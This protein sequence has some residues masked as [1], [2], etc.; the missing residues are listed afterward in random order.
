MMSCKVR[1]LIFF[2]YF[3]SKYSGVMRSPAHQAVL[4]VQNYLEDAVRKLNPVNEV[5]V[6]VSSRTDS[7]VHA[8]CNTAHVDIQRKENKPPFSEQILTEALNYHLKPE[9]I[10]I[11]KSSIVPPLFHA[12]FNA[13]SRT[14]IYR[15]VTG[16]R[17]SSQLP[18]FE[19]DLG[20]L[21]QEDQLNVEAMQEAAR[22]FLGTHNFSTFRAL[23]SET[24]YKSPVKTMLLADITPGYSYFAQHHL[25]RNMQYWDLTFK[26]NS[27]LYKQVRR[28]TGALVAV[29]Q[30]RL[31][32]PRLQEL[33]EVQDSLAFPRNMSAP[34]QGLFLK[35]VEYDDSE[36][37]PRPLDPDIE[38]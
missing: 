2:Q 24:P 3:G 5:S 32:L 31:T 34:P 36:L 8:L 18:V 16:L 25:N 35:E 15:L 7:G 22:L 37:L 29:G 14:Y 1:Y 12:R 26:S 21:V 4:G 6:Y 23:N 9:P 20:W 27:F 33:L 30:G 38:A 19:K 13:K 10:S 28:M 11:M 17:N